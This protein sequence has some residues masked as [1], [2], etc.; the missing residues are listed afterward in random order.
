MCSLQHL[1]AMKRAGG[2][3]VGFETAFHFFEGS[4][5]LPFSGS[6]GRAWEVEATFDRGFAGFRYFEYAVFD[7]SNLRQRLIAGMVAATNR[8]GYAK[9]NIASV[10]AHEGVE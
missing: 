9:A 6:N 3:P 2:C 7:L 10:I 1:V 5:F 8:G 4:T